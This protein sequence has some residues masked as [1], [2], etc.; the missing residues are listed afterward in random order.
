[1]AN[2]LKKTMVY[3]GLADEELRGRASKREPAP[4][5]APVRAR[6]PAPGRGAPVTPLRRPAAAQTSTDTPQAR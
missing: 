5:S 3:L 2:P 1:M 4:A 6:R